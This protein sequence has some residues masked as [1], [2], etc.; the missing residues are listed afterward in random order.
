MKK[1]LS[2]PIAEM[3][4]LL[5][6]ALNVRPDFFFREIKI[7]FTEIEFRK[8][9]KLSAKEENRI[10]E[11]VKDKLSRYLELE[12]ILSI[13]TQFQNPLNGIEPI[14]SFKQVEAAAQKVRESWNLGKRSNIQFY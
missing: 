14:N 2:F 3:I 9:K 7:E 6:T 11:Q 5:S 4:Q 12:E 10:I 13:Q 1:A 8:L